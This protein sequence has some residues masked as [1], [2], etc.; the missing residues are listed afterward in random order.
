MIDI[1]KPYEFIE[2]CYEEALA[3]YTKFSKNGNSLNKER[4]LNGSAC[5]G[6]FPAI[7]NV[8]TK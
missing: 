2:K 1:I 3:D 4:R 8:L 7:W 6:I 5:I